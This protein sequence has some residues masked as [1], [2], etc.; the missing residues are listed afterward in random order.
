MIDFWFYSE[1]RKFDPVLEKLAGICLETGQT[2]FIVKEFG[3][4][5]TERMVAQPFVPPPP[6]MAK[7]VY[8]TAQPLQTAKLAP[9]Q[10]YPQQ[11][12][13]Q[14]QQ[15]SGQAFKILRNLKQGF[16]N[17]VRTAGTAYQ[18]NPKGKQFFDTLQK[19][20]DTFVDTELPKKISVNTAS[21]SVPLTSNRM[22][23]Q[24]TGSV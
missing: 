10:K 4:Y 18:N 2:D 1:V 6:T 22:R 16:T 13:N 23:G 8:P 15:K 5:L 7:R 24:A 14:F 12:V 17:V 20:V 21:S 11:D 19:V 9:P 3:E